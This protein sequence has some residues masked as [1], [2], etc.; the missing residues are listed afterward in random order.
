MSSKNNSHKAK[1]ELARKKLATDKNI[2]KG[3]NNLIRIQGDYLE[4]KNIREFEKEQK[5]TQ[6]EQNK[7][8]SSFLSRL[9]SR[10]SS[11]GGKKNRQT[12]R[13]IKKC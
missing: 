9:F 7:K 1:I 11:K 12:K 8:S 5:R 3:L 6:E 10:K 4:R 13:K 2:E